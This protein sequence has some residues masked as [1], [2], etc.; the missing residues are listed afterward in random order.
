MINIRRVC[1]KDL[2]HE[3]NRWLPINSN[4]EKRP[5][6]LFSLPYL[7]CQQ[8]GVSLEYSNYKN[9]LQMMLR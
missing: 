5:N 7:C 3:N 1:Y 8:K 2:I 4:H 6:K 9:R